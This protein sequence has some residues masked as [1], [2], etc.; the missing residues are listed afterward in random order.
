MGPQCQH[1]CVKN[2]VAESEFLT[3]EDGRGG[4]PLIAGNP[5]NCGSRPR[6]PPPNRAKHILRTTTG[7]TQVC[8]GGR[9]CG[10]KEKLFCGKGL[11]RWGEKRLWRYRR[12]GRADLPGE[13][14]FSGMN[15]RGGAAFLGNAP[16]R[17]PFLRSRLGPLLP[18]RATT[19]FRPGR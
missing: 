11:G 13:N 1:E 5:G 19:F 14:R 12:G 6:R 7:E 9:C 16:A 15:R 17:R 18:Q 10:L 8:R 4:G 2:V 3:A